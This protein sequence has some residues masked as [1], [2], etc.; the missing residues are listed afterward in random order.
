M[1]NF[2]KMSLIKLVKNDIKIVKSKNQSLLFNSNRKQEELTVNFSKKFNSFFNL[3]LK[4]A[5]SN[6]KQN[7]HVQSNKTY[8]LASA[9]IS[10]NNNQF[11][12]DFFQ[13]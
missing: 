13:L 8:F 10:N 6:S 7:S 12:Q 9:S 1:L 5:T 3:Y 2:L 11:D 4:I